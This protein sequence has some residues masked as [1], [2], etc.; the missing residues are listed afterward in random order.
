MA[1]RKRRRLTREERKQRVTEAHARLTEAIDGLMSEE[2][3]KAMLEASTWLRRYSLHNL[4]M[5]TRQYPAASDVRPMSEWNALGRH[6]RKGESAIRIWAPRF[7]R[8]R[9]PDHD[10]PNDDDTDSSGAD[11]TTEETARQLRGF[12]LVNVFDVAQT[13][14]EPLP[15]AAQTGP[16]LLRGSAPDWLWNQVA[17]QITAR[18]YHI[19]R[20]DCEGANGRTHWS[21]QTVRVRD[22]LEDAQATKT[23]IHELAHIRC[24]HQRCDIPRPQQE[25]EAESVAYIVTAAADMD[26]TSY[27]VPYVAGWARDRDT[28]TASAKRVLAVAEQI[29]TDLNLPTGETSTQAA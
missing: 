2:G 27:S 13:E 24:G 9:N 28:V 10:D 22:D 19:E 4:L 16:R 18:G 15:E 29:L 25:V 8:S 17:G 3:W 5:I 14:G 6:V 26:S 20:G 23:L 21:L 12:L 1:T 11:P 7:Q